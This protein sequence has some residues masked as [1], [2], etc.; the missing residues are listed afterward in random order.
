MESKIPPP[1]IEEHP[2]LI[3]IIWTGHEIEGGI[4]RVKGNHS[5]DYKLQVVPDYGPSISFS[6]T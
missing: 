3:P 2:S 1:K 4:H 5:T 6:I